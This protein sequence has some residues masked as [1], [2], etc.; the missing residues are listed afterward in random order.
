MMNKDMKIVLK[1]LSIFLVFGIIINAYAELPEAPRGI[2]IKYATAD[3]LAVTE[4]EKGE[5]VINENDVS[6]VRMGDGET[7]GGEKIG[8][9]LDHLDING[10]V[11]I[12]TGKT[13]FFLSVALVRTNILLNGTNYFYAT[14]S[15][16]NSR[17]S[18]LLKQLLDDY[19]NVYLCD[20]PGRYVINTN[21]FITEYGKPFNSN[22]LYFN[23]SD[24]STNKFKPNLNSYIATFGLTNEVDIRG[25]T[26]IVH[27]NP[28]TAY[29]DYSHAEGLNTIALGNY[30]HSEGY[31]TKA[32]E[33]YSH[34]EGNI[35]EAN[36][37]V[38]H[39]EG[40]NTKT[41][42]NGSHAEGNSTKTYGDG[43]HAEGNSTEAHRSNSHA[44]GTYSLTIG[45]YSHA[46]GSYSKAYGK[47][48]H[49]EGEYMNI[50]S[51]NVVISC[52][53]TNDNDNFSIVKASIPITHFS[54]GDK[55]YFIWSSG[56][57]TNVI[58]TNIDYSNNKIDI[59][60]F[61]NTSPV[62]QYTLNPAYLC[63][64]IGTG[65]TASHSEGNNTFANGDYSH[66]EGIRS[67]ANEMASFVWSGYP[68]ITHNF[69]ITNG[70][71]IVFADYGYPC[72][73]TLT[74]LIPNNGGFNG[75]EIVVS[76]TNDG[77]PFYYID[78]WSTVGVNNKW[79]SRN[80]DTD[81]TN[82]RIPEE[83]LKYPITF[84]IYDANT[85]EEITNSITI[86]PK[87]Y[88][89]KYYSHGEGTFNI[90]P[91]NGTDGFYIGETNLQDII[92]TISD[93]VAHEVNYT[94]VFVQY[95]E[96]VPSSIDLSKGNIQKLESSEAEG[97]ELEITIPACIDKDA[98]ATL[99]LFVEQNWMAKDD[100]D[101]DIFI[102]SSENIAESSWPEEQPW[103]E[104][105]YEN[106]TWK[107]EFE[108]PPGTT[109]W[110][111][112]KATKYDYSHL[113]EE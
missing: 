25:K 39:T 108:S 112:L 86:T 98:L 64:N 80:D 22:I 20:Y 1:Q 52:T 23:L 43:S 96:D 93:K 81:W 33:L 63:Q 66:A 104:D 58:V 61:N 30:S 53:I 56:I 45:D 73:S 29:G 69:V 48:S 14:S 13:N 105:D 84:N 34:A 91:V 89:E 82:V 37:S 92:S 90:N 46:E 27:G 99:T 67:V 42:G 65:G 97:R 71:Q 19:K 6:D 60:K 87:L 18:I 47:A 35:T 88:P 49:S 55:I 44:E 4:L 54:L 94:N 5:I 74:Q 103:M 28:S 70:I 102:I 24:K 72:P 31:F 50:P 7:L 59:T 101:E 95:S 32:C 111:Y 12:N 77:L 41:Y 62:R 40:S 76:F 21:Y 83:Y 17:I 8:A 2:R 109:K 75:K 106:S 3:Q 110:Y 78:G 79:I 68:I 26:S 107:I 57:W 38:S 16:N 9:V 51:S 85:G 113:D 11:S 10:S 100:N 15:D 36:G